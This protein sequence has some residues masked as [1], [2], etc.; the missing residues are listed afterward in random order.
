MAAVA[1]ASFGLT[2]RAQ[3]PSP[4]PAASPTVPTFGTATELVYVR[5]HVEKKGG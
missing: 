5:F 1:L 2:V 4:S 3:T